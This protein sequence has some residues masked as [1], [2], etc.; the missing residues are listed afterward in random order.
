[1]WLEQKDALKK[2][3]ADS[4]GEN[5]VSSYHLL[6]CSARSLSSASRLLRRFFLFF[7]S[8]CSDFWPNS[9]TRRK[10]RLSLLSIWTLKR[11][12]LLHWLTQLVFCHNVVEKGWGLSHSHVPLRFSCS[13]TRNSPSLSAFLD[14]TKQRRRSSF[15]ESCSQ[16]ATI[17]NRSWTEW[18]QKRPNW[19]LTFRSVWT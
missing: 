8:F 11:F 4:E 10:R 2:R 12:E 17:W 1:M 5:I 13:E 6:T 3:M 15:Q 16:P 9:P 7:F 18:K 19:L 14:R